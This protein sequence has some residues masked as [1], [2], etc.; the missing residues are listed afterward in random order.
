MKSAIFTAVLLAVSGP[1][2]SGGF[3]NLAGF[4]VSA[5]KLEIPAVSSPDRAQTA[6]RLTALAAAF[7]KRT[8]NS[9]TSPFGAIDAGNCGVSAYRFAPESANLMM[10]LSAKT[11]PK[12]GIPGKAYAAGGPS[13]IAVVASWDDPEI[14]LYEQNVDTGGMSPV[15]LRLDVIGM[16]EYLKHHDAKL[17]DQIVPGL[18]PSYLEWDILL[19]GLFS[20]S[21]PIPLGE[22]SAEPYWWKLPG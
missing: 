18:H 19:G 7:L 17:R 6:A 12:A 8:A 15:A 4:G 9:G 11:Y 2:F 14:S 22:G 13:L 20:R 16:V 1:A 10:E 5:E 3:E 21:T